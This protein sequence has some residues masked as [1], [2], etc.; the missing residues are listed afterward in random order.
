[1]DNRFY[2]IIFFERISTRKKLRLSVSDSNANNMAELN[3]GQEKKTWAV[4]QSKELIYKP[5]T[6]LLCG[7]IQTSLIFKFNI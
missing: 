1:M 4:C 7:V 5:Q 2:F 3:K 6:F